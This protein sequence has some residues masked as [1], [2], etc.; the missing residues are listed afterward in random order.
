MDLSKLTLSDR[1]IAGSGIAL[2]IFSFFPWYGA[3]VTIGTFS[4]SKDYSGWHYFLFGIIPVLLA[5]IL[6]AY[7]AI[8]RFGTNVSLPELPIPWG[9]AV[10]IVGGLAGFLVL[11]KLLIGDSVSGFDLDRK[12]GIFLATLAALGL[13]GGAFLKFREE[14]GATTKG[15]SSGPSTPF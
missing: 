7:V 9:L 2:L 12:F 14:G 5:L 8:T 13:A 10:L 15:S 3:S 1:I 4:A 6:V 11:L